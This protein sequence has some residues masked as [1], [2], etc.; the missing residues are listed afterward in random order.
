MDCL[1]ARF[2]F[3][4]SVDLTDCEREEVTVCR[5]VSQSR[6]W[7]DQSNVLPA[8]TVPAS[9]GSVLQEMWET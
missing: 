6:E 8:A 1:T 3:E 5:P 4:R 2:L 9:A 7:T